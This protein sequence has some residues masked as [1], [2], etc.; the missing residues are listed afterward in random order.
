M[1]YSVDL[2]EMSG[3]WT[4]E[5]NQLTHLLCGILNRAL[6]SSPS[7]SCGFPLTDW[8]ANASIWILSSCFLST[9]LLH[10]QPNQHSASIRA[11]R[12]ERNLN[13]L[14]HRCWIELMSKWPVV[15]SRHGHPLRQCPLSKFMYS[16][17]H[18]INRL[19]IMWPS[20]FTIAGSIRPQRNP[21][22]NLAH[23]SVTLIKS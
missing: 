18:I 8:L 20:F 3:M 6:F 21:P 7:S 4:R 11:N 9:S 17:V 5:F 23:D 16:N 12:S 15:W 14:R 1:R 22:H 2:D 10:N 13:E 19:F